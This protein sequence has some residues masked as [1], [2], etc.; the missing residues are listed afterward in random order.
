[1]SFLGGGSSRGSYP[2]HWVVNRFGVGR[3][4]KSQRLGTRVLIDERRGI[5]IGLGSVRG[6]F[7]MLNGWSESNLGWIMERVF[8][9]LRGGMGTGSAAAK[10]QRGTGRTGGASIPP[11]SVWRGRT[12][13]VLN[14]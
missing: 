3:G 7:L 10:R 13:G 14:L 11:V 4:L 2:V 5:L 9:F 6:L 1:M 8:G 12:E